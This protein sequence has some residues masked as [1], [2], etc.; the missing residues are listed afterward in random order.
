MATFGIVA[1]SILGKVDMSVR[2]DGIVQFSQETPVYAIR[3]G[4]VYR[5]FPVK[6]SVKRGQP[7]MVIVRS[8]RICRI[9]EIVEELEGA[10][11]KAHSLGAIYL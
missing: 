5:V 10:M 6:G 11:A 2:G 1:V 9:E 4:I 8:D 7:L 3:S